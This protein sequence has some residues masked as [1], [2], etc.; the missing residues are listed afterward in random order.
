ME[1][2]IVQ[3]DVLQAVTRMVRHNSRDLHRQLAD[4][5]A[6]QNISQAMIELR[7]QNHHP[8]P[9]CPVSQIPVHREPHAHHTERLTQPRHIKLV[10]RMVQ[11][12]AG[13][14]PAAFH[15]VELLRLTDVAAMF[16][17][18]RGDGGDDAGAVLTG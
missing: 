7:H 11:H 18:G 1:W 4:P 12:D 10:L 14:E 15:I 3:I 2:N 16:E 17:D 6:V 8:L 9:L 13:E 5:P